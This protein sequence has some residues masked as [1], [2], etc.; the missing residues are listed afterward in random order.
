MAE[1]QCPKCKMMIDQG[2]T[3]CPHCRSTVGTSMGTWI[4][5]GILVLFL[6]SFMSGVSK[7]SSSISSTPDVSSNPATATDDQIYREFEICM[8]D[9]KKAL[10]ENKLEGR[11]QAAFCVGELSKYGNKRA[12][13]AMAMYFDMD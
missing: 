12:K 7:N 4:I 5:A 1:K 11:R 3:K 10:P 13:K 9:A 6:I 8:N 2:A